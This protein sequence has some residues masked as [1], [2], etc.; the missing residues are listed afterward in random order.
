MDDIIIRG[1]TQNNLKNISLNIP[2]GKLVVFTG[3][4][5]SG[6]SSIVFDTIAAE[7]QRQMN[8]TYPAFVR[9]RLPKYEKPSVDLI[10]NLTASVIV[11]QTRLGGNARSTVGTISDLYARL[12]LLYSRVGE[13][14]VGTASSFSFNDPN[15]MCKTCAGLGKILEIDIE[16]LLDKSQSWAGGCVRDSLFKPGSWYWQQY[17]DS[18]LFDINK[19]LNQYTEEEYNL[20]LY[21]ARVKN[22]V[23][24]NKHVEGLF[25]QYT[26]LYLKRD[27]S[28]LGS[29]QKEKSQKLCRE[30]ECPDCRG[31]RLNRDALACWI[32]GH[33]IDEMCRM[34]FTELRQ[35][36]EAIDDP[37][38]QTIKQ[39]LCD[40][41]TRLIEI[42]LPYLN[43]DRESSSLSGGEAQRLKLVRFMGSSLT[44]MTYIFDEPSTGMH[45]RD[46]YRMNALLRSLR[47]R[48]NTILV[49]EHD[50]DVIRIADEVIDIGPLA[51]RQG[52]QVVFQGS[53]PELLHAHTLTAQAMQT[54]LPF[55][56]HPRKPEGFL[57]IRGANLHNLKNVDV[58]IPLSVLTVVSG[59]AG[60]GKSSLISGV[61]AAQYAERVIRVDQS[62]ITATG[63]S[64]PAT[65]LGIFDEIRAIFARENQVDPAL[66]SFNSK[67]ACPVCGGRG[68]MVTE[69]VFMDPLVTT[70]EACG[71][72]RY[73]PEALACRYKGKNILEV[74]SMTAEDALD[75]FDSARIRR[76]LGAMS[77]VGLPYLTIGQPLSTLSGGERQRIKLAKY[78][79]RKGNIYILDEPSTGLHAS[80]VEKLMKLFDKFV[81]KGNTVIM[82]EHNL[83]MLKR[84]D[85][86]IDV[87]QDGGR[88]GG[89]VVFTGTVREMAEQSNT[90][91]AQCLRASMEGRTLTDE[92]LHALSTDYAV[93]K[94]EKEDEMGS[95]RMEPIGRVV[96]KEDGVYLALDKKYAPALQGLDQFGYV[97]V[98]WW[99]DG[100]DNPAER[101]KLSEQKPYTHGPDILGTFATRSPSRPNPLAVSTAKLIW[102]DQEKAQLGLAYIDAQNGSPV[103]DIKPY[104]PSLD[105]VNYPVVP[106]WCASWPKD[107]E[108]SADFDWDAEFNESDNTGRVS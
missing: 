36:L 11:D 100:C 55:K 87:G 15:G 79:D 53:Y 74:L 103:L 45:P 86:V 70:C 10:D 67:G 38:A 73:N 98:T 41:L 88:N 82:I 56:E 52:G 91:T 93:A 4:S 59:V 97:Q 6:K 63:R 58:D 21:G 85:F 39:G 108:S 17:A 65:F 50:K 49:V 66:F 18:G 22:G 23:Q 35:V 94:E 101:G 8:E 76:I 77:R 12:R 7:S 107:V 46:V 95:L 2:R 78:L 69:L 3:V 20:L 27:L 57:P 68:V 14:Y 31:R 54:N 32:H 29:H 71:G 106:A 83:E 89:E 62:P 80:D 81:D 25:H 5:G 34:E 33:S 51:G 48:G 37:R 26:R 44:Q 105:R 64:M 1:L 99:F 92:E 60:S 28:A 104:Q 9:G 19:P 75:F 90:I 61:F 30:K 47:D 72:S 24:E 102:L 96:N 43:M 42:G 40:S 84:A 16:G 13:P